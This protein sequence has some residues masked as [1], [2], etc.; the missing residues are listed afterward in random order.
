MDQV[1]YFLQP[2][3]PVAQSLISYN[4]Q[5]RKHDAS[6]IVAPKRLAQGCTFVFWAFQIDWPILLMPKRKM[7]GFK[8]KLSIK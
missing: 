4:I 8:F 6:L 1:C 5:P 2:L 7:Q 3:A